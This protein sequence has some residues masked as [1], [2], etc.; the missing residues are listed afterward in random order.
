M[1]H[2][3][4]QW[5]QLLSLICGIAKHK[6]LVSCTLFFKAIWCYPKRNVWT[7]LMKGFQYRTIVTIKSV[8]GFVIANFF[9][10][11]SYYL[12]DSYSTSR[13]YLASNEDKSSRGH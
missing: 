9:N 1:G 12:L 10:R 11:I 5:H 4:R 3:N 7:L 6:T 13:S 8:F 2:C